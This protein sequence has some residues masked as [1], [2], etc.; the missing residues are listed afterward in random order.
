[1]ARVQVAS[2]PP[3]LRFGLVGGVG[4]AID[5]GLLPALVALAGWGPI[6]ARAVSFPAAVLAT[7]WLNRNVTFQGA[8]A[9]SAWAS[10]ARYVAVSLVGSS[11]NVGIYTALVLG[12]AALAAHPIVPFA[13]AS[14]A[15][16]GFN[17]LGSKHF[18][19]R[20]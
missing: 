20:G 13:A 12:S 2:L 5:G 19:F 10:L 8:A 1:M 18:A 17:Y 15:A 14:I 11:V 16:L 7:W 6:A 4:F 3:L 9:G